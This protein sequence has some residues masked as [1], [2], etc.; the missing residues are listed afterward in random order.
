MR[1]DFVYF[2]LDAEVNGPRDPQVQSLFRFYEEEKEKLD[3]NPEIIRLLGSNYSVQNFGDR[4]LAN[5][6]MKEFMFFDSLIESLTKYDNEKTKDSKSAK[7][8]FYID[9]AGASQEILLEDLNVEPKL[10]Q[11]DLQTDES[12]V[13]IQPFHAVSERDTNS[14]Y[15]RPNENQHGRL[16]DIGNIDPIDPR[17]NMSSQF[18]KPGDSPRGKIFRLELEKQ[19]AANMS[20][21][22]Q[23]QPHLNY[24]QNSYSR[25]NNSPQSRLKN[26]LV[27]DNNDNLLNNTSPNKSVRQDNENDNLFNNMPRLNTKPEFSIE[28][29][30][31]D[32]QLNIMKVPS[33]IQPK[34]INRSL[35]NINKPDNYMN[36]PEIKITYDNN[37]PRDEEFVSL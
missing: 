7:R 10:Q 3:S 37:L 23:S 26:K 35:S 2:L 20:N 25:V 33:S 6:F 19:N 17:N 4:E 34:G 22:Y 31:K 36:M 12:P 32:L 16:K 9:L 14:N 1:K 13:P 15:F 8:L 21:Q 27:I 11:I 28:D 29:I 30:D 5:G 18:M 24:A